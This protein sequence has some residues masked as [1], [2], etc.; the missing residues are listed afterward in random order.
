MSLSR[1]GRLRNLT[2]K[3]SALIVKDF[4]QLDEIGSSSAGV[5]ACFY[6]LGT[7]S[8]GV[9]EADYRV[10]TKTYALEAARVLK[11][12]SP[13][14]TFHFVSGGS[15]SLESRFMWARVKAETEEA[16]KTFGLAGVHLLSAGND[17]VGAAAEPGACQLAGRIPATA[18]PQVCASVVDRRIRSGLAM[19]QNQ[20]TGVRQGTLENVA[21][22]DAADRYRMRVIAR[23]S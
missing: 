16:L 9:K 5:D 12:A 14:H 19:L 2:E 8:S 1:V 3:L 15:T 6:C 21:I 11:A 7:A 18:P 23:R 13:S 17:S 22:R 10:I 4:A 20:L